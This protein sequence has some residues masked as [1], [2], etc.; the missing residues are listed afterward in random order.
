M[1]NYDKERFTFRGFRGGDL[2]GFGREMED[3]L[4]QEEFTGFKSDST[5]NPEEP[6]PQD[7]PAE[8]KGQD[9]PVRK[10]K[11]RRKKHYL[12]KFLLLIAIL[13]GA[14]YLIHSELFDIN[15]IN[16]VGNSHF[17]TETIINMAGIN[18]GANS[19][20]VDMDQAEEKLESDPYIKSAEISRNLPKGVTITVIER[21]ESAIVTYNK[22]YVVIDNCGTV[23]R[24]A[25]KRP[26]LTWLMSLTVKKAASGKLLEV[27]E[28][29]S[30]E[31][32]LELL[33]AMEKGNLYFKKIKISGVMT[34][35][36]IS[37]KL[38]CRGKVRNMIAS[39]ESGNLQR[40]VYDL[41]KKKKKSGII[42]IG[43]DQYCSY[44][45]ELN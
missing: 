16:V 13:V 20:E 39:M 29:T 32:A 31:K 6:Y 14:R 11:K 22:A 37:D 33:Q 8:K 26:K 19:F 28:E 27:E 23:L 9:R 2:K 17:K 36:Y 42:N 7:F 45:P 38:L 10:R 3:N 24:T 44:Q 30:L 1:S 40:V 35:A 12:L 34:R 21:K 43:D 18:K 25:E 41:K 4:K 15:T 5:Y